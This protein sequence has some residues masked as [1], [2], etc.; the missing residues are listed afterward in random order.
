MLVEPPV[1]TI[2]RDDFGPSS[3]DLDRHETLPR[4]RNPCVTDVDP[5]IR[6]EARVR[7]SHQ[8]IAAGALSGARWSDVE[9]AFALVLD[10]SA[11]N[12]V[13]AVFRGENATDG[14]KHPA[15]QLPIVRRV[16]EDDRVRRSAVVR[17]LG[18]AFDPA[19][20]V[21]DDL[22]L[23]CRWISRRPFP[24]SRTVPVLPPEIDQMLAVGDS[25]NS[26][27]VNDH[28]V[29]K[30]R[31][32]SC[33]LNDVGNRGVDQLLTPS[34]LEVDSLIVNAGSRAGTRDNDRSANVFARPF[35]G[36]RTVGR[37][38]STGGLL[39]RCHSASSL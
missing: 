31:L 25:A 13:D 9:N 4:L 33:V 24:L 26:D 10:T 21:N 20:G 36:V 35:D 15:F 8:A 6:V 30:E 34:G 7:I 14:T 37:R 27:A 12:G 29:K 22:R 17:C 39:H 11:V 32:A 18:F 2:S 1:T 3:L 19:Q 16:E 38:E 28:V 23:L 5:I